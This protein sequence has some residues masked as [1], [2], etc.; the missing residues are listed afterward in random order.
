MGINSPDEHTRRSAALQRLLDEADSKPSGAAGAAS[1]RNPASA[2][3]A[4]RRSSTSTGLPRRTIPA[5]RAATP[6]A[7]GQRRTEPTGDPSARLR[8]SALV[9]SSTA[10]ARRPRV[11]RT[12]EPAG[13]TDRSRSRGTAV[14]S[15]RAVAKTVPPSTKTAAARSLAGRWGAAGFSPPALPERRPDVAPALP[16]HGAVP[17][18]STLPPRDADPSV[19]SAVPAG[20]PATTADRSTVLM[21]GGR[22]RQRRTLVLA[23]GVG[24]AVVAIVAVVSLGNRSGSGPAANAAPT[25]ERV[26]TVQSTGANSQPTLSTVTAQVSTVDGTVVALVPDADGRIRQLT[27]VTAHPPAAATNSASPS[28]SATRSGDRPAGAPAVPASPSVTPSSAGTNAPAT[29]A[30][31]TRTSATSTSATTAPATTAPAVPAPADP[32]DEVATVV[33][34]LTTLTGWVPVTTG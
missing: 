12:A 6:N 9:R 18:R 20:S 16:Q 32:D 3:R 14:P 25:P 31:A 23:G 7:E 21:P 28:P 30:P 29:S 13:Q 2:N 10:G 8:R 4:G 24:A 26:V 15:P 5:T 17:P 27:V 1:S 22:P 11:E 33:T 34:G 19:P